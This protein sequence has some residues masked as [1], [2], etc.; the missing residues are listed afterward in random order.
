VDEERAAM[1]DLMRQLREVFAELWRGEWLADLLDRWIIGD[2]QPFAFRE[3]EQCLGCR[4]P[5]PC[6]PFC[7]AVDRHIERAEL[8]RQRERGEL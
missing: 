8:R 4:K 6:D 1:S 2:H 7:D 5:W 3:G